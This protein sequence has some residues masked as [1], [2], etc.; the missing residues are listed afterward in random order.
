MKLEPFNDNAAKICFCVIYTEKL[1]SIDYEQKKNQHSDL[2]FEF[3]FIK[4][5]FLKISNMSC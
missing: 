3:L 1:C 2:K 5:N 4:I